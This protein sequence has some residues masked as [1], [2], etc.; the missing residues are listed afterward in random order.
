MTTIDAKQMI[1]ISINGCE[2]H[3][4]AKIMY[5]TFYTKKNIQAFVDNRWKPAKFET[6]EEKKNFLKITTLDNRELV[7]SEDGY[8]S[9]DNDPM[10]VS[11]L[12]VGD[13]IDIMSTPFKEDSIITQDVIKTIESY[14]QSCGYIF[15]LTPKEDNHCALF[16][17]IIIYF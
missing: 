17:G 14:E 1:C 4:G 15:H 11:E 5:Q 13:S 16:N 3:G 6:F 7:I 12:L 10:K 9:V 2:F 8:V